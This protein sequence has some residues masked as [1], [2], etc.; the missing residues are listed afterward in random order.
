[1][2][3]STGGPDPIP[4]SMR[5]TGGP[6]PIPGNPSQPLVTGRPE[7]P[8]TP[9]LHGTTAFT[10][11][12]PGAA[13]GMTL[14]Q[15]AAHLFGNPGLAAYQTCTLTT[16]FTGCQ[17]GLLPSKALD[18]HSPPTSGTRVAA[19]QTLIHNIEQWF[20]RHSRQTGGLDPLSGNAVV[21]GGGTLP[22]G[23]AV[24][25]SKNAQSVARASVEPG[26]ATG[27]SV[28]Y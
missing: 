13:S 23:V 26:N 15:G 3:Y 10:P 2:A 20:G 25:T 17:G 18:D 24:F 9:L 4:A 19:W 27:V 8:F 6:D 28:T 22:N 11:T 12:N 1:M 21:G 16:I 7:E 14:Q 5:M